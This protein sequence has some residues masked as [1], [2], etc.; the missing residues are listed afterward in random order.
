LHS[1]VLFE[2]EEDAPDTIEYVAHMIELP[3]GQYL[4]ATRKIVGDSSFGK[5]TVLSKDGKVVHSKTL[6]EDNFRVN[7][8]LHTPSGILTFGTT[9]GG[10]EGF[11]AIFLLDEDLNV[12][13][14]TYHPLGAFRASGAYVS[15]QKDFILLS[16]AVV[17]GNFGFKAY[18][19]KISQEGNILSINPYFATDLVTNGIERASDSSYLFFGWRNKFYT[20]NAEL[21]L[22]KTQDIPFDLFQE[23]NIQ[24]IND[25]T[26]LLV[27]KRYNPIERTRNIGIGVLDQWAN[28]KRLHQIGLPGDTVDFPAFNHCIDSDLKNNLFVGGNANNDVGAWLFGRYPSWFILSKLDPG[29][30]APL[31]T[32]YFGGDAYYSMFGILATADDGCIMYGA[33]YKIDGKTDASA[34]ML[35]VNTSLTSSSA[36]VP[37]HCDEHCLKLTPNPSRGGIQVSSNAEKLPLHIHWYD[38]NGRLVAN[39]FIGNESEYINLSVPAGIYFFRAVSV[40]G[41]EVKTGRL[42]IQH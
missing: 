40:S 10:A 17:E 29:I 4:A 3:N 2:Y 16:G 21:D 11:L 19:A 34:Y 8:L 6:T 1:Q 13:N 26:I 7:A 23:G 28:T 42:I 18:A 35:K 41:A 22:V 33:R 20:L 9:G 15:R 36:D 39:H 14:K 25:T 32:R 37:D 5:L 27:G 24:S 12:V 31:W 30:F 38:V